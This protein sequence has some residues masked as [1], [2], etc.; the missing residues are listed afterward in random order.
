MIDT[1]A[2]RKKVIDLA[3]QGK[4]TQQLPKD[5]NAEELYEQIQEEKA[6]L[7][8]NGKIKKEKKLSDITDDEIPF[9]IPNNWKFVRFSTIITL[10]SGQDLNSSEYNSENIGI[11][12]ITGASNYGDEGTIIINRWTDSP[13]AIA[14]HGDILLSCKGTVGKIAILNEPR[15]HI[16]RQIMGI[17]TYSMNVMYI[18]YFIERMV[19]GIKEA[20]K[21][22][23]PG[24]ERNDV[25]KLCCPIP[26]LSEQERIVNMI[27]TVI[28]E[29]DN[30]DI[31][32]QQYESDREILKGKIIDAG[33]HGK[34]TQQLPEDGDA[35]DLYAHIQD[36]K[37]K[38]IK[39][40]KIKKEK[41]FPEISDDE[42]P[43]DIPENWKWVR[44]A[45]IISLQSGQDL[46]TSDY[47]NEAKGIPYITGASNFDG[48]G[49]VII[50]RWTEYPKVY[51]YK[52]Y[53][54]LSCKG[55]VGKL[56]ILKEDSVHI[57]RQIMGIRSFCVDC[58]YL[59]YYLESMINDIKEAQKGLI[60]GIERKDILNLLCPLP[61]LEEQQR[62]VS[63]IE[64]IIEL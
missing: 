32:Q 12:Y 54:L 55:T 60:P 29:L 6:K 64:A 22:L 57:A 20:S 25:L 52:G 14:L 36:E 2:L 16:A 17:R 27:E 1:V 63:K 50:N 34:L 35:D 42:I 30:I 11:P 49:S 61:P 47:N 45:S 24:I 37:A 39:E 7:I 21:G 23:I 26:P 53:I 41:S 28:G 31:L 48:T 15:V 19:D 40:G 33:I 43:F 18:R 8:Q 46:S 62:I 51:A 3:I 56:T 10:L 58:K 13:K 44:L 5:G 38:L 4:L 59:L 9:E